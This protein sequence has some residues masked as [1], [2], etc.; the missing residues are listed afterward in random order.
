V[1]KP[2][3]KPRSD[4]Q[5]N[6]E[7]LLDAAKVIFARG[8][9]EASLEAVARAAGVGI[10][11]LYRHFPTREALYEAVYSREV[12]DL[13]ALSAS[14]AEG[15][16]AVEALRR[17]LRAMIDLVA[18]KKGMID[19]LALTADTTSPISARLSTRLADALGS[20]IDRAE[21]EGR[22]RGD[23]SGEEVLLALVGVCMMRRQPDWREGAV[24]MADILIDGMQ[25]PPPRS[26]EG[27]SP[28]PTSSVAHPGRSD[29]E[30]G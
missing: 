21:K 24:K 25:L 1:S 30:A 23:V 6:R 18:T 27:T 5:R 8:S 2:G 4:A 9:G 10:G 28:R 17:W 11:T 26:A 13:V 12:G 15:T 7:Q 16:D 20:M 22:V 14:L 29:S 19:A 3:R